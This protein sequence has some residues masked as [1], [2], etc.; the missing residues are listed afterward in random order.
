MNFTKAFTASVLAG[1]AQPGRWVPAVFHFSL[2]SL[3]PVIRAG[4]YRVQMSK[5]K[6]DVIDVDFYWRPK[7][8]FRPV[9]GTYDI[10][11]KCLG[12][13]ENANFQRATI[14]QPGD[15][16]TLDINPRVCNARPWRQR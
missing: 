3:K 5:V 9:R 8:V 16:I 2:N 4:W 1:K 7:V 12:V 14:L 11:M 10:S 13:G 6:T 15:T